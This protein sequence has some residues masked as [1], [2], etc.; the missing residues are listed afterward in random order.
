[1]NCEKENDVLTILSHTSQD[2]SQYNVSV[3]SDVV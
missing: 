2:G 1:M 3:L